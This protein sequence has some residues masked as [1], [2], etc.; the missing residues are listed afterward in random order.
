MENPEQKPKSETLKKV[1]ETLSWLEGSFAKVADGSDE[2]KSRWHTQAVKDLIPGMHDLIIDNPEEAV[3]IISKFIEQAEEMDEGEKKDAVIDALNI[4]IRHL[5]SNQPQ[6]TKFVTLIEK[7]R[8]RL[9][10][11]DILRE[12]I[13]DLE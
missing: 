9:P 13:E 3:L 12:Y 4:T 7:H 11:E 6:N 1:G 2:Y 10:D 8:T 5:L